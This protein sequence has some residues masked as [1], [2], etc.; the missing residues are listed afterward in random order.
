MIELSFTIDSEDIADTNQFL[1]TVL[2]QGKTHNSYD[3]TLGLIRFSINGGEN[4]SFGGDSSKD[5]LVPFAVVLSEIVHSIKV[6]EEMRQ[7]HLSDSGTLY[8][9]RVDAQNI[10]VTL[11]GPQKNEALCDFTELKSKTELFCEELYNEIVRLFPTYFEVMD[12]RSGGIR[13]E[14]GETHSEETKRKLLQR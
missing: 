7:P 9:K 1:E 12:R 14:R 10:L 11:P 3:E 2:S 8:Y 13:N 4:M 5:E 6:G